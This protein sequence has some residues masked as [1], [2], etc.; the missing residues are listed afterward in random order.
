LLDHKF[1]QNLRFRREYKLAIDF[2]GDDADAMA[3]SELENIVG[4]LFGE[5]IS[6]GIR[7]IIHYAIQ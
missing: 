5:D 7:W 6:T 2:I 1:G 4:M 3:S